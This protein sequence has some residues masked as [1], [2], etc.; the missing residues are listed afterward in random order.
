LWS[1][2]PVTRQIEKLLCVS[3]CLFLSFPVSVPSKFLATPHPT[4]SQAQGITAVKLHFVIYNG[5]ENPYILTR[6]PQM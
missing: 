2:F 3:G 5:K 1:R 4:L 6:S